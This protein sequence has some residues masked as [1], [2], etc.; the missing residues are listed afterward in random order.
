MELFLSETEERMGEISYNRLGYKMEIIRYTKFNDITVRFENGYEV[1]TQYGTFKDG[2]ILY[3][4]ARTIYGVGY[5]G[6]GKY[7]S[8]N[9][10]IRSRE[11]VL[12]KNILLRCYDNKTQEKF[13]TYK[14]CTVCKEWHNFQIFAEWYNNNYY[15]VK[16]EDM[17]V[18]K[19]IMVKGNKIYSPETCIFTPARINLLFIKCDKARGDYPIGAT[20]IKKGNHF[21]SNCGHIY[22]GCFKTP[23]E[24]FYK[25]K[26]CKESIIKSVAEEYKPSI[27]EKLY[28]ALI[29]YKVE[30]TD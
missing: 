30:I 10:H 4:Y 20:Y 27:P 8:I 14:G 17:H 12:W 7:K 11:Y 21:T 24:A 15:K 9:N 1:N 29:N 23:E 13:P 22:L 16:K 25:Y 19:D 26:D 3:P 6:E 2:A 28:Q 5:L 18:D